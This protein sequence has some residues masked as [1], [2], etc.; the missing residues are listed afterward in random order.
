MFTVPSHP[1]PL[2]QIL[3]GFSEAAP[4]Y[5]QKRK[6]EKSSEALF[7]TLSQM[8]ENVSPLEFTRLLHSNPNLLPEHRA[9]ALKSYTD[10]QNAQSRQTAANRQRNP[11]T[12]QWV[13]SK[14]ERDKYAAM[15][16]RR[17]ENGEPLV[18]LKKFQTKYLGWPEEEAYGDEEE[19]MPIKQGTDNILK[20]RTPSQATP[21]GDQSPV[22]KE[23]QN[24]ELIDA[25]MDED[26]LL[27]PTKPPF[28]GKRYEQWQTA[29]RKANQETFKK[30]VEHLQ[31]VEQESHGLSVLE[32]LNNRGNLP[33]G[34]E[35][36]EIDPETGDIRATA[37]L[38]AVQHPDAE[39]WVK[40]VYS[41]LNGLKGTFGARI[42]N[43]DLE[44]FM[45]RFPSLTNTREG[46]D[47]IL[48]QIKIMNQLNTYHD[49]AIVGE[50]A[51]HQMENISP[52]QLYT[53][54]KNKTL[55]SI[56]KSREELA[57]IGRNAS[58]QATATMPGTQ[59][60]E[61]LPDPSLFQE[62]KVAKNEKGEPVKIIRNGKWEDL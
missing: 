52:E 48:Q 51:K 17:E 58:Q 25:A 34:M 41:M 23:G 16:I 12:G 15:N 37:K 49:K 56:Q 18:P 59:F 20:S 5:L 39:R 60:F 42:T 9:S 22:P 8:D 31:A 57:Q 54:A 43:F 28:S 6:E 4:A 32:D 62:G 45:K 38:F 61:E 7:N 46:R 55:K 30:A 53:I 40:T 50:I 19:V 24:P 36:L 33:Q 27:E 47:Q 44:S 14:G 26:L 1:S 10:I 35:R 29:N 13:M 2:A 21:S 11:D 3:Q